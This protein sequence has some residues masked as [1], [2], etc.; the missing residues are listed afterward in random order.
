MRLL[1]WLFQCA[2]LLFGAV[3]FLCFIELI[4]CFWR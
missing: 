4:D 1:I 2:A 3:V